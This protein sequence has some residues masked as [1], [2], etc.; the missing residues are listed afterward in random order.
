[1]IIY[2]Y[3]PDT[4]ALLGSREADESPLE[5]GVFLMPAFSTD[6]TPPAPVDGKYRIFSGESWSY[7]DI[8]NPEEVEPE[9]ET[10]EGPPTEDDYRVAIQAMIDAVAQSRRYDSGQ[11]MGGYVNSTVSAWAVEAQA[12]VAWRDGVWVYAYAELD[13]VMAGE[14]TQPTV[15]DFLDELPVIVWP[16]S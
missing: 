12:F 5:P 13:K 4:G 15:Q 6:V 10:E 1:M 16:S 7:A 2:H 8:P 11:A 9:P 3:H 14:R